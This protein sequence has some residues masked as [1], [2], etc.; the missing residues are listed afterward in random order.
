MQHIIKGYG[1]RIERTLGKAIRPLC[2]NQVE[3]QRKAWPK[4]WTGSSFRKKFRI[5]GKKHPVDKGKDGIDA[6]VAT[7]V[8]YAGTYL[9][10]REVIILQGLLTREDREGLITRKR[11]GQRIVVLF[12]NR[13]KKYTV[14]VGPRNKPLSDRGCHCEGQG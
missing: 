13:I 2:L 7:T 5:L 8:N 9:I 1:D 4:L 12:G 11:G 10:N 6:T 3:P 14:I